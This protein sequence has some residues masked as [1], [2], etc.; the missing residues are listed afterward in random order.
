MSK[1]AVNSQFNI[2]I[3][4]AGSYTDALF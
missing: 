2:D 1:N 3:L 4:S